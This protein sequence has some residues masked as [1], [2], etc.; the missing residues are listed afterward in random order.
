MLKLLKKRNIRQMQNK[1]L[2][3]FTINVLVV[4]PEKKI[5]EG[6][7]CCECDVGD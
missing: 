6:N 3:H 7:I 1:R 5:V 4:V 2:K